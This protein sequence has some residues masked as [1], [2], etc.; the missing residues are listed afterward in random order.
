MPCT[1]VGVVLRIHGGSQRQVHRS[2]VLPGCSR[3]DRGANQGVPEAH[4]RSEL[5][6]LLGTGRL[7]GVSSNAECLRRTP[8][9]NDVPGRL[10][11]RQQHQSLGGFRQRL[12]TPQKVLLELTGKIRRAGNCETTGQFGGSHTPWQFQQREGVSP[13]FSNDTVPNVRIDSTWG[14]RRQQSHGISVGKA[15]QH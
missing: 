10:G 7:G 12:E 5:N 3:V 11:S 9:Q 6:E 13:G 15:G 8:E 2:T 1:T 14:C 4:L